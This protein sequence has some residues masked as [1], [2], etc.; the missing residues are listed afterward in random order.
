MES[1]E[2]LTNLKASK[3]NEI[4]RSPKN[5]YIFGEANTPLTGASPKMSQPL[6]TI[7]LANLVFGGPY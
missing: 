6:V 5:V 7:F 2:K 3:H 4:A 1:V